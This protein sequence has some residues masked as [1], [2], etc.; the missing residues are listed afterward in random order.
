MK[1]MLFLLPVV[2]ILLTSAIPPQVNITA[3]STDNIAVTNNYQESKALME[4]LK[5]DKLNLKEKAALKIVTSKGFQK[6]ASS[7]GKSQIIAAVLCFLVGYIG[8]H[9][10][11]LGYTTIGLIQL[12][13]FGGFGI[14]ALIDLIRIITGDLKPMGGDYAEKI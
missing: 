1:K 10:F 7:E 3:V 13:T 6:K 11:Y 9:R 8:I 4:T 14:W 5:G 12:L 2:L